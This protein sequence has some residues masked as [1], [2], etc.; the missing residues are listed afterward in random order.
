[1]A[2]LVSSVTPFTSHPP[3]PDYSKIELFPTTNKFFT[4]LANICHCHQ[5]LTLFKSQTQKPLGSLSFTNRTHPQSVNPSSPACLRPTH[6]SPS[7]PLPLDSKSPSLLLGLHQWPPSCVKARQK[8]STLASKQM[9][10]L[11]SKICYFP[12]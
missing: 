3:T 5:Q 9:N 7:P 11:K 12:A 8:P 4:T 2:N 6:C 10:H 1:M